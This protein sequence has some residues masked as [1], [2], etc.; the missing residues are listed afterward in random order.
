MSKITPFL[1]FDKNAEEAINYYVSVFNGNPAKKIESKVITLRRYPE[2]ELEGPMNGFDGKVLTGV[3]ELEGE[4]FMALDGGPIFKFNESVSFLVDC[5][6]QEEIDYFWDTLIKDGGQESQCGWLKDKFGLS[7]Q[8]TP[9]ME[10][11]LFPSDSE[12]SKRAM[13]AMLKMKKI[14]IAELENA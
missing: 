14:V 4:R 5:R 12:K 3:F 2:G 9:S 7:W 11:F 10:Q 6:D 1:W 8:I 13:N